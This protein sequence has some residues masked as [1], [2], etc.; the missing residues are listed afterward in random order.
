M[1]YGFTVFIHVYKNNFIDGE[2]LLAGNFIP[3]LATHG[4]GGISKM[5]GNDANLNDIALFGRRDKI[6]FRNKLCYQINYGWGLGLRAL[7]ICG[8]E[9]S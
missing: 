2:Y 6:N 3:H 9:N 8:C 4:E 5:G 7:P 1:W